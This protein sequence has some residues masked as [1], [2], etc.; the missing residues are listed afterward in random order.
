MTRCASSAPSGKNGSGKDEVLRY[1]SERYSVSSIATGDIVRSLAAE[2]GIDPTREN[3]RAISAR[4]FGEKGPGAL[5]RTAAEEIARQGLPVAGISG[6]RSANDV[7][8]LWGLDGRD[9]ALVH[10]V[11]TDDGVRFERMR[12]RAETR[13]PVNMRHF[14]ELDRREEEQFHLPEAATLAD[15][16]VANDGTLNDLHTAIDRLVRGAALLTSSDGPLPLGGALAAR[17]ARGLSAPAEPQSQALRPARADAVSAEIA[18]R[19]ADLAAVAR[20]GRALRCARA[21]RDAARVGVEAEEADARHERQEGAKRTEDLAERAP[22]EHGEHDERRREPV[23]ERRPAE[24]EECLE[25]R[26]LQEDLRPRHEGVDREVGEHGVLEKTEDS[27]HARRNPRRP[28][29]DVEELL[30]RTVGTDVAAVDAAD[31]EREDDGKQDE[32]QVGRV[33]L[34]EHVLDAAQRAQESGKV[35]AGHADRDEQ[36]ELSVAEAMGGDHPESEPGESGHDR[37]LDDLIRAEVAPSYTFAVASSLRC[38]VLALTLALA[39]TK[40]L[41]DAFA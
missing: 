27:P 16:T 39:Q 30:K 25:R 1:L 3:L 7:R 23:G 9:V 21:A 22:S 10:V 8:L 31:D 34:D 18:V 37:E 24:R 33:P 17:R 2:E 6:V 4:V 41:A 19:R 38:G 28:P 40:A 11:V 15:Y 29:A 14:R 13:D 5:V 35:E 36:H 20:H 12:Q 26:H 32:E